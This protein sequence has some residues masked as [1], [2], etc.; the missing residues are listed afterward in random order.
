MS[1]LCEAAAATGASWTIYKVDAAAPAA[2]WRVLGIVKAPHQPA[3][4]LAAFSAWP[5]EIDAQQIQ[6]GFTARKVRT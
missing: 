2:S 6:G 1:D 4:I 5:D 3:A